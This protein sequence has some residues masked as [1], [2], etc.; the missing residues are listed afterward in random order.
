MKRKHT[1][2]PVVTSAVIVLTEAKLKDIQITMLQRE[3]VASRART[4]LDQ[5]E[6]AVVVAFVAAGL[7]PVKN[8]TLDRTALTATEVVK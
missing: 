1:S 6:Q 2:Q 8:Y 4:A 5:A 7:D 3:V